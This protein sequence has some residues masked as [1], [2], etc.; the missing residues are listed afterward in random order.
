MA[1][2][3]T[4]ELSSDTVKSLHEKIK[5][6]DGQRQIA[7]WFARKVENIAFTEVEMR[8]GRPTLVIEIFSDTVE[9]F[10]NPY[11]IEK[12]LMDVLVKE[13]HRGRGSETEKI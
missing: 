6:E 10:L 8:N 11:E 13:T 9:Y 3:E 2:P 12:L 7:A 1:E 4:C 5:T